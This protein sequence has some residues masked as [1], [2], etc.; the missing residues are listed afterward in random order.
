MNIKFISSALFLAFS[1]LGASTV[2]NATGIDN[3][4][5]LS[6]FDGSSCSTAIKIKNME[7]ADVPTLE[8]VLQI[9]KDKENSKDS[10]TEKEKE[11]LKANYVSRKATPSA[12]EVDL[13]P[14]YIFFGLYNLL[15]L[16]L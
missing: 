13:T 6:C 9:C 16:A 12:V 3:D 15:I 2:A 7:Q 4:R 5:L 11:S 14:R 1:I 8:R 10:C